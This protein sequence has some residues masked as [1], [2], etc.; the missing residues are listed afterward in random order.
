VDHI[1]RRANDSPAAAGGHRTALDQGRDV[2][3]PGHPFDARASVHM[4]IRDGA[5]LLPARDV[6]DHSDPTTIAQAVFEPV[7]QPARFARKQRCCMPIS[8]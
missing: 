6:L 7:P 8:R 3:V 4:L 5:I 1:G 2:A